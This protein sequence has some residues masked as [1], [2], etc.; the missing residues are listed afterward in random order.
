MKKETEKE[1][2][3]DTEPSK[4]KLMQLHLLSLKYC[5]R[6]LDDLF[7]RYDSNDEMDMGDIAVVSE[8]LAKHFY[9]NSVNMACI[10]YFRLCG[11]NMERFKKNSKQMKEYFSPKANE[12]RQDAYR[13]IDDWKP[14]SYFKDIH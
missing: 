6:I 1:R 14:G 11:E 7:D 10:I 3:W 13:L 9:M 5:T 8:M 12:F 4:E 2:D